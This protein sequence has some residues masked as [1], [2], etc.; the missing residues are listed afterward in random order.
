[1]MGS[2]DNKG[3]I[4]RLCDNLFDM[5]AKQQSSELT[6]KV[7]VSYM[8]IY[9]EKVHDLLDPKQ[10]KQSLKVREHNVLGPYVDGL[11]QLA[12]TSFQDIDNLMAEGN[13]SR[14]VAAT[15]MNSESS[16]SHAVFSVILTQTLTDSKSGVSGEKVSR[17]S[18]VDLAGSERA[19]KTGAVG[20]RL[21]EG[22]NINKSL[23]T[24]GLVISK[25]ADQNSVNNNKKKDNFVP[26]RDSVLT[27]LLKDNLGG[28]SKTVMVATISPA[29]DNYEETLSTLRYA[30][31][32]KRIV[33]HAVVNEDPNARIIRELRQEVETLKEMLLHATGSI[34]GQQRTDI[35]EKLSESERLM[36]EMSQTWEEKLVKTERLQHERQHALEKMGISVQASGIQVEKNKYYLVNL[37][38]DPSLNELL[39]YYLKERTLVG[40]RSAK[41]EQDIQ[42]HGLG[43][44][45]EHC[46]IT[47]EESGLYMTPLNGARCFVN[48]TQVVD[49][50]LLQ[51]G[52]RI[53]WGNHHFFRVNCPRSAT[54][55]NSEPQTPAQ[56]IDYNFA[57][58]ELMLNE[59]SNDPI[60][61]AIAR[62]EKQHEED[63]QV[64]LEKQRQEYERQFQQLRNILSPSTPYSPYVPYDPLRGSQ[65]GKLPACTPT[66]QMRVE[67]WAQERDEMFKRSLGQL[68]TDILKANALVQEA[69]FLAEEM[70]KQTKFSVT[71]QIPPNN[72]SPNRKR[73]AFVSEPAIL[74]KRTNTGSQVWSMEKLENKLVDMRDMY[75]ERKD[76]HNCQR[77]PAIKD[78]LPGK[79]QDPF[80]ESQENHN[81]I[82]VANIFL[83]VLFHDVRL[84]Y[85]TP[86]ISQQGEVAGRLQVEISRISGQFPQDRICEAAS[87]S[88]ADST[89]SEPEDYSGGSS[90]IT[91]R[92]TIKQATGLPLSLSHFVFCQ[93]MFWGHPEPIVVPPMVNADLPNSNCIIGQR[94]SLAFKFD[95]TK[96]FTVPITEEFME[97]AS[98]GA[99]SIEV[100]GHRS[101]GF[102]RSKPGWEV[103]QQQLAKARSLADRWSELTRKIELWVEIQELNEQ[104][105]YSPV[106]VAVKQDTCTGGIYQ[107]RQG[108]QRRIQVRVKPVQNSG[109]LP[110]I[111]QSILN[112][113][114]GSVSVRNR[115]Q[116]P[117]DSYQDED[118]SI[119]RE[120]W[121]DALMRRRQYLDQQI[122]KLINKQDKT[123][124]DMERE[125]SLVD[126]WVSLTEE[127]NA[128][129]VPA[130]GSGIPGAPADWTPPAGMEPHIPV[131]FLDLN[132][133]DLSTH[134]SGEEVSVTGLNS[135]L[136]KEHGNK[137]Y[138]LPIIR[139]LE[140]DVC[141]IAAWDS[142]IHDNVHLNRVTDANERV[143]LILKTTVRLSHPA[144]MDLVLRKRLALN[145]YKRQSITDR[146]FKRIVRIDCLTQTGVTYEV[147]SNIPKASE[148]LEDRESLAQIAASGEDNSLCDGETY[149]EKYTRGVS[150]VESILTLDRLRQSVAVKELLQAQGQPLMR[151]TASV[152]N[153]SQ[154][155][156]FDTSMDS[157][158]VTRSESVT[159]LNTE[160]NGLPH[161]RRA[162]IGHTRNDEN[163]ISA[164]PKPFGIASP[165]IVSS[166]LGPRMTTL[167]EETSNVGNQAF[168]PI[169]DDDEEKSDADYSEYEAYQA[170][171]K[172]TKPLTSSR[173]LDSLVELQST[174]INTPSMSSSGYG[175]QAVSTTN[176]TSE[177]S[178]SIKSI[179]VD[180]TPDLE[181]RNP[182]DN[183]KPEKMDS[184]LV[185]E[186]PEEY[187]GEVNSALD[188]LD[189]SQSAC[190]EEYTRKN[191][192]ET[193]A[194]VD[195]DID[196]PVSSTKS[197]SE[198][199]SNLIHI[200]TRKKSTHDQTFD[201]RR[202]SVM[203]ISQTSNS[204]DDSP[205]EGTSVVH[206]KL[207]PGKVVRRKK[208]CS[209]TGRP[210]S[211]QHRASFPMVRP[212][213]S[214]SKA[215]ARLEQTLQSNMPYENGDNSS[216]ERIDADDV[217]DK[218]SAFGSRH[219]LTRVE[220]LLPDW[221]VVG[222]SVLVRPY[223]Y[224]GVIAYVGP[225]EFASGNWIGVELDAPTGKNDGAVNGHRYFTCR[226]KCG[227]FV[228]VDKLIQD[229]RGRA[230]RS[231]TK[232]EPA[233]A[234][235]ALMRRSVSKGEGLHSLHRSRS[236]GEG[237]STA[238]TLRSFSRGK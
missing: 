200:E 92:V 42:L 137:F 153:F 152:P 175:S 188:N 168:T 181:Y 64:A 25:L 225:T 130:A 134:Q 51:H 111:C 166:K 212:Q 156:R 167:H 126:Q 43:I 184:S 138:N 2:G 169:N 22:S 32:A 27:W 144:P 94:D 162:S 8:E 88:S 165:N 91:C 93:Y 11:S 84:D 72:L 180:E 104:G 227:I 86:I 23:T 170:P 68:K 147:V 117:L 211:S 54:A 146:I 75:E 238:G 198:T 191:L 1:M 119:L 185:E 109:T 12:V 7:E 90:H 129:L 220:T 158:N 128:V 18:L 201:D 122:Q 214:E 85:H 173:T 159:D 192:E 131:L 40:G 141:A 70:G 124:Q 142:S 13:K 114:V 71:L 57:R 199:N 95:H 35:T 41:T 78:E 112:I 164:P 17:M 38:D 105:E 87:E 116:I 24:L 61:R 63:K 110:I 193:G 37:N 20:D 101:A 34:V 228:K 149:I 186:T 148:E 14:T 161:P 232:Q 154:I 16:R 69:N 223:S 55:I 230:L 127:R 48:G 133:D 207:P 47:I 56:N 44:L 113:A 102:S 203:E 202:K 29:A 155:M 190:T 59:L 132:A 125:Q 194:Y 115:L 45:P 234:P 163:F 171:P 100:W 151:K 178:I 219:D 82:G 135:I 49:K 26:Y 98:E 39:V 108:Q 236:R 83:E 160:M 174:K 10:N 221:V 80:Y 97:H 143:F 118:L 205:T 157:L 176:L 123:E 6:Y 50:T 52:D 62:L 67:K 31:R 210:T 60:Q 172:P 213:L 233:P 77:L 224:S 81:L 9:N 140:K 99:L 150:A 145:I 106:E 206:T 3:I 73:G 195:T 76:P 218:S 4:P 46:V 197:E 196:S 136:P 21:K 215:A 33:N 79:T 189:I 53:V 216:S 58:E 139:H 120:K 103:E 65:S 30:D 28:N 183:K 96:D 89:S 74:V 179:S 222:E 187:L 204:G 209:G 182:I 208:T 177:D 231:Y 107:L 66:T 19:V 226:P 5:I 229:R 235:S 15:N 217:S 36:K 237:L 121:S